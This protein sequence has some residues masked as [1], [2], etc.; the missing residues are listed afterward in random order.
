MRR[1]IGSSLALVAVLLM[2][3][4]APVA[5]GTR[6]P[7]TITVTTVFDPA[8]DAFTATGIPGCSSGL[9]YDGGAHLEFTRNRGVFAGDKVFDCGGDAGFVLH[10]SAIFG[11]G[12]S[13]GTWSVIDAW[14]AAVGISGAGKLSGQPI[15][16][17]VVDSYTG[18]ITR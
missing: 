8:P 4:A 11:S 15:T 12:G 7:V 16:N 10:L 5:A 17:G 2:I 6:T 9:V 18:T 13:V 14:G 1:S 3:G